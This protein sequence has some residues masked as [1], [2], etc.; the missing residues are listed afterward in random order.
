MSRLLEWASA[1]DSKQ[2]RRTRV[3]P[4]TEMSH[5]AEVRREEVRGFLKERADVHQRRAK[6]RE[7]AESTA[8]RLPREIQAGRIR[9]GGKDREVS[10]LSDGTAGAQ[11]A[12]ASVPA[13]VIPDAFDLSVD[14][15][16]YSTTGGQVDDIV[17]DLDAY[18]AAII[19]GDITVST[20]P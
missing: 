17:A 15:V 18:K 13:S 3:N 5:T 10:Y 14:G 2:Q 4:D 9:R 16:G 20:T 11:N 8:V 1:A 19:N 12:A 7:I 6:R